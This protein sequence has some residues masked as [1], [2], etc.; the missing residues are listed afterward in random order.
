M[1]I[2]LAR[3]GGRI[4]ALADRC[5][6]RG[7]TLSDGTVADGCVTCPLHGSVFRLAD[8]AVVRGPA[9]APEPVFDV[10]VVDGTVEVRARAP[11]V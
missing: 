10:R 4:C 1:P 7:G 2:L 11:A 9:G 6:H 3:H 8:G 5:T